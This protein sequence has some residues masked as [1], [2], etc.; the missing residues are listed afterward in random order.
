MHA[1]FLMLQL[2]ALGF[3]TGLEKSAENATS[4]NA[5]LLDQRYA[6]KWVQQH[7]HLFG[8]DA[9]QVT[10]LGQS[11]GGGSVEYHT[12]AYGGS[13][14]EENSLFARAIAQSPAP[15][16]V[17]PKWQTY[18]ANLLLESAGVSS[19]DELRRLP[20][21]ALQAAQQKAHD[22]APYVLEYFSV[23]IRALTLFTNVL[24]R[25]RPHN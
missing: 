21:E 12:V 25:D 6:L 15:I 9:K 8:G 16:L 18:G 11:A 1:K 5:G 7:I 10:I 4:P 24:T 3:L 22:P 2:G 20:T 14:P 17:E 23:L 19:V 13:K